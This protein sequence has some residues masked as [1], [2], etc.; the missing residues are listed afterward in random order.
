MIIWDLELIEQLTYKHKGV[1]HFFYMVFFTST[2][3]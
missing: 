2:F 3:R 1:T